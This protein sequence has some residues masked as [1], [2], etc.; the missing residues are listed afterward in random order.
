M[1]VVRHWAHH[2]P[3]GL[4]GHPLTLWNMGS[5]SMVVQLL[6]IVPVRVEKILAAM[7]V[8]VFPS[9]PP[10]PGTPVKPAGEDRTISDRDHL[11]T[12]EV[13]RES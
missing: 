2:V 12:A 8:E 1:G 11:K 7:D 13:L 5:Q 10:S 9:A 6:P 3:I 4:R